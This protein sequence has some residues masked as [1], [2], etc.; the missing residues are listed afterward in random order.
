MTRT[1]RYVCTAA[2]DPWYVWLLV[3]RTAARYSANTCNIRTIT[4][5]YIDPVDDFTVKL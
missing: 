4:F 5:N 3:W 1:M 2:G